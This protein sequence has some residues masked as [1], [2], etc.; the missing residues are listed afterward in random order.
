VRDKPVKHQ[1][2]Y[3]GTS[4]GIF[5]KLFAKSYESVNIARAREM[6]DEGAVL[7]DVRT[8]QEWNA[9]HAPAAFHMPLDN[10]ERHTGRLSDGTL[11]VT[12]CKS[13]MR[14]A[15]AARLLAAKGHTV[16]S[17]KGGMFAWQRSGGRVV[18]KK[19]RQGTVI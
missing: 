1:H 12:I 10:L 13:G 18:A 8:S 14:S 4:I 11:V 17:V 16:A 3:R 2:H 19:G 7:I 5:S 15:K 6:L 9:G